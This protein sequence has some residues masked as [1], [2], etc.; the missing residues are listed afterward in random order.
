MSLAIS[1]RKIIVEVAKECRCS[2]NKKALSY[3]LLIEDDVPCPS[4]TLGGETFALCQ[5]SPLRAVPSS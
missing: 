4:V 3:V 2:R 1:T 5:R